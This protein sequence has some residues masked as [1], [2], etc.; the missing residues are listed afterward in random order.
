MRLTDAE[1]KALFSKN[2]TIHQAQ[3]SHAF[4]TGGCVFVSGYRAPYDGQYVLDGAKVCSTLPS[5]RTCRA[6]FRSPD[7]DLW[8]G[9]Y[10]PGEA[11]VNY[12]MRV[13]VERTPTTSKGI[14]P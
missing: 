10:R 9:E 11:Q 4:T 3:F 6:L 12:I 1:L 5:E 2:V 13:D 14:C 7:G 8:W